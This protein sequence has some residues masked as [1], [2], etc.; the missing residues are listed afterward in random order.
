VKMAWLS[1]RRAPASRFTRARA[2]AFISFVRNQSCGMSDGDPE[3]SAT[4]VSLSR[5]TS[6]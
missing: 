1:I 5:K 4:F 3:M 2:S 6:L